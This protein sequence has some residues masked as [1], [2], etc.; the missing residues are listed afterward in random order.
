MAEGRP[1]M[2]DA[3]CCAG[4]AT[5]GFQEAGFRVLGVD[6]DPQPNYC[7]DDFLQ[8]DALEFL[9]GTDFGRFSAI[10]ASPPCQAHANVTKWRGDQANH[11]E[12]IAPTRELLIESG[13]PYVIEN[14]DKAPLR[15]DFMLCGSMF[16]LPIRRHRYFETN[17]ADLHLTQ[18]CQHRSTDLAFEHKQERAY[19]DAM[20]CSWMTAKEARQAVP[21]AFTRWMGEALMAHLAATEKAAA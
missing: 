9:G 2:I 17:W 1:W 5:K 3:Y 12:L 21:P 4:G 14:V 8:M 13:L 19:A 18:P 16:D 20:G 11:P 7:G 6:R 15:A 10:A